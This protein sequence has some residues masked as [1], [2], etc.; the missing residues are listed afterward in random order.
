MY[1]IK[2]QDSR[3]SNA[4]GNILNFDLRDILAVIGERARKA[5][6][7]CLNLCFTAAFDSSW[8]EVW[9]SKQEVIE[10]LRNH[11]VNVSD[12]TTDAD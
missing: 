3:K 10:S 9:S 2:I 1:G 4:G 12:I 5:R 6:W 8:F 7:W 11:F